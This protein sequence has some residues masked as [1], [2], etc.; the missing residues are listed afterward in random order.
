MPDRTQQSQQI[1]WTGGLNTAL[2]PGVI[3]NN[4]LVV[5]E[6]IVFGTAGSRLKREGRSYLDT[7]I[8]AVTFRHSTNSTRFL[9]FASSI[10]IASPI[11][12]ILTVGEDITVVD[13]GNSNYNTDLGTIL[14]I[15]TTSII[16]D[17]IA[18]S[19][20]LA[21]SFNEVNTAEINAIVDRASSVIGVHDFWY[22]DT[23]NDV[24]L[25]Y[26]IGITTQGKIFRYDSSGKREEITKASGATLLVGPITS[27][28]MKTF[29]NR[30]IMTFSGLGNTPKIYDPNGVATEYED[31]SAD[32]PDAEFL[33]EHLGRLWMNDKVNRERLHFCET[34]DHTLWQGFGDSGA[35]DIGQGDGDS[36]GISAIYPPFKEQLFVAKN[37]KFTKIIGYTPETFQ[38]VPMSDGIGALSHKAAASVDLDDVVFVSRRGFHSVAATNTQGSF[39]NTFLS[40]K[41][42]PSFLDLNQGRLQFTQGTYCS[43]LNSLAFTVAENGQ[44]DQSAVWLYSTEFNEWY[45]WPEV[46][47]QSITTFLFG[48]DSVK[49]LMG[50]SN[51]RLM[52]AQ[53]GLYADFGVDAYTYRIKSGAIYPDNNAQTLKGFKNLSLLFK[54]KGDF[55]F[56]VLVKVD[57]YQTQALLYEQTA[58]SDELGVDFVLGVSTLG[59]NK[60]LAP[61]TKGIV[62]YGRGLS[63]EVIQSAANSQVEIYG[64]IIEFEPAGTTENVELAP[65]S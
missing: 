46:R 14:A 11:D 10:N 61:F 59:A 57:N 42:Q 32:A 65:G 19:F 28:D 30:L 1:P 12:E 5:C 50:T 37:N 34:F 33:Q 53:N 56:T 8:P 62:G 44:E 15:S 9:V 36:R 49:L 41:I 52:Y 23:D 55:N 17:T 18:Y 31:L 22:Y 2:D 60:V 51:G 3:G 48:G 26:Q 63:L 16:N 6:N 40:K 58:G 38:L 21:A 29:N 20:D 39:E 24:K 7:S 4:D 35:V 27:C 43:S 45:F 25:Q 13:A 47:A 54:P 64:Y